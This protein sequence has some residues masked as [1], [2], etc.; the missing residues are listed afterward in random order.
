MEMIIFSDS[1][2]VKIFE[3]IC[4]GAMLVMTFL[5]NIIMI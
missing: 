3:L 2:S 5:V 4:V 1:N